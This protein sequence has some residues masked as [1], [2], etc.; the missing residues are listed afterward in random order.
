MPEAT[1]AEDTPGTGASTG[2]PVEVRNVAKSYG[3]RELWS[4]LSFSVEAGHMTALVGPSG[5]GKS[6]LLNCL[7]L[8]ESPDSGQILVQGRD[9]TRFRRGS[10]RRFRR[11]TL[12][13]LFQNYALIENASIRANLE[14][15]LPSWRRRRAERQRYDE[16]LERVGLLGREKETVYRLS[17]GEQQ[18]VA[19]ARLLL[20]RPPVILAD[21]PTGA[22]DDGNA[23]TVVTILRDLAASGCAV[24]IATH[25][26][27]VEE[28][29]DSTL[30]L[31]PAAGVSA[32]KRAITT[33]S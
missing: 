13:Y 27:R 29:C 20:K 9:I 7:G 22:L 5:A 12:G 8:L 18:R 2:T 31:G 28:L 10:A 1:P 3:Q 17:G 33:P 32:S 21:E 15:A 24:I 19:L 26:H 30:R 16:I 11:D 25:N 6:T 4:S 14:V 23:E